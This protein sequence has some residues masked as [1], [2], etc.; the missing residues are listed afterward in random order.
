MSATM[1]VPSK[2][3]ELLLLA[4]V[5]GRKGITKA[6]SATNALSLPTV[7]LDTLDAQMEEVERKVHNAAAARDDEVVLAHHLAA[8]ARVGAHLHLTKL[9]GIKKTQ[10]KAGIPIPRDTKRQISLVT[11]LADSLSDQLSLPIPGSGANAVK[12]TI[13]PWVSPADDDEGDGA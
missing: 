4:C 12:M 8:A 6:K 10:E 7:T 3:F 5:H 11:D 9:D 1:K 13:T 2:S